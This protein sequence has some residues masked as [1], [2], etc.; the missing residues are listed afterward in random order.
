MMT[1]QKQSEDANTRR[2]SIE[3]AMQTRTYA[4]FRMWF[5]QRSFVCS[6]L[7]GHQLL[8]TQRRAGV[9]SQSSS[10]TWHCRRNGR[11]RR[12]S[13]ISRPVHQIVSHSTRFLGSFGGASA[14]ALPVDRL[15]RPCRVA[16]RRQRHRGWSRCL[17][18]AQMTQSRSKIS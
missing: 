14:I 3:R 11:S 2:Q 16:L 18:A 6:L 10:S 12:S 1:C 4:G 5:A 9:H 17:Q 15:V 7:P 8:I 13:H